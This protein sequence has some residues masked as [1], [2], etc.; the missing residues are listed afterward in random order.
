MNYKKLIL[1]GGL[2]Y[3]GGRIAE[4][5]SKL[6]NYEVIITTRRNSKDFP[7]NNLFNTKIVQFDFRSALI[8]EDL[9]NDC[10]SV[11]YLS[12]PSASECLKYLQLTIEENI[13][14]VK[15]VLMLADK[16]R[17]KNFIYFSSIHVYG[18]NLVGEVTEGTL[19]KPNHPYGISHKLA[20]DEILDF[21]FVKPVNRY[22]LRL[23]NCYGYPFWMRSNCWDLVIND[24]CRMAIQD[25]EIVL[26][27]PKAKRDFISINNILD[28]LMK[29][30]NGEYSGKGGVMNLCS[31][32][33]ISILEKTKS[34]QSILKN[35]YQLKSNVF[36]KPN[37]S[38]NKAYSLGS[39]VKPSKN[40]DK[41]ELY[42]L[43]NLVEK[44]MEM[45]T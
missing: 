42:E 4:Y 30:I 2:G 13:R 32:Q 27:S 9:F 1:I 21:K 16:G 15:Q 20:E 24:I 22:I 18:E 41:N 3:L 14:N 43:K 37:G 39:T 44:C 19:P 26:K 45:E 35:N 33:N 29:L 40:F 7:E 6:G 36:L 5:F 34:I 25:H 10:H 23:S 12:S 31:G 11:I 8:S 28:S 17:A 38:N